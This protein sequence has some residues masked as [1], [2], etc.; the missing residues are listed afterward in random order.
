[1]V[2]SPVVQLPAKGE[3]KQHA[4]STAAILRLV[5]TTVAKAGSLEEAIRRLDE[6]AEAT[7]RAQ[8][9]EELP[10]EARTRGRSFYDELVTEILDSVRTAISREALLSAVMARFHDNA[11]DSSALGY[12]V[13]SA[14]V[15]QDGSQLLDLTVPQFN[16]FQPQRM[17]NFRAA[18]PERLIKT[19]LIQRLLIDKD[20]IDFVPTEATRNYLYFGEFDMLFSDRQQGAWI[21]AVPLPSIDSSQ[22]NRALVALYPVVGNAGQLRLPRGAGQEARVFSFLRVGFDLLNHQIE[23]LEEQVRK[24]RRE[25][26]A[27]L[28]PGIVNHEINQQIQVLRMAADVMNHKVRAIYPFVG[29]VDDMR[30]LIEGLRLTY[31]G[32]DRLKGIA[33]AFN[34]LERRQVGAAVTLGA[35]ASEVATLLHYRIAKAGVILDIPS[36]LANEV[37]QIDSALVEHVFLNIINNAIDAFEERSGRDGAAA[38]V[39][40]ITMEVITSTPDVVEVRIGNSGPPI[41]LTRRE[42]IFEKGVT[43]KPFG[44]GHGIGLYICRL[45]MNLLGGHIELAPPDDALPV[46]FHLRLPRRPPGGA[47]RT[48]DVQEPSSAR[49]EERRQ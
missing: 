31:S 48:G 26:L 17:A 11:R 12:F 20:A 41:A 28:G 44:Q 36:R 23:S 45:I 37:L 22:P 27:D 33:D 34:N 49:T 6:A 43:T 18:A 35:L 32:I 39:R 15:A 14:H 19:P 24:Q 13:L 7:G 2:S 5:R 38:P 46:A 1:M 10:V 30:G 4:I 25:I 42:R 29:D 3:D 9:G 47:G 16:G 40:R 21:N 8:F